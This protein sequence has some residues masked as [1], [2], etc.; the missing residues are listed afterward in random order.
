MHRLEYED[1]PALQTTGSGYRG[2]PGGV[3]EA[4][5]TIGRVFTGARAP[6]AG[7]ITTAL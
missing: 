1:C 3:K 5:E 4:Q 6:C 7:G 2:G